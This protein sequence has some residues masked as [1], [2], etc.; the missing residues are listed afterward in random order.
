MP[1]SNASLLCDFV[2]LHIW[3]DKARHLCP[4]GQ[5]TVDMFAMFHLG[6]PDIFPLGDLAVR[7]GLIHLYNLKVILLAGSPLAAL[8]LQC[9]SSLLS[10][11]SEVNELIT[12]T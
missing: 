8:A 11:C 9:T 2:W 6:R 3:S 4:A 10:I 12:L 1:Q 5:W 7:K